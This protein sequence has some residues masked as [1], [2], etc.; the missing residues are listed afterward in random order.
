MYN[1]NKK[2]R[3]EKERK[4]KKKK[5]LNGMYVNGGYSESANLMATSPESKRFYLSNACL[6]GFL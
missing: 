4:E 6:V 2:K 5:K 1:Y 3:K